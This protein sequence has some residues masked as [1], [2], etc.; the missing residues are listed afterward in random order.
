MHPPLPFLFVGLATASTLTAQAKPPAMAPAAP[1]IAAAIYSTRG[2]DKV[3]LV[4]LPDLQPL[5]VYDAGAGAHE[6]AISADGKWALGSAYGGPGKGHQPADN[7]VFVLDLPAGKRAHMVDLGATKR[8]N[9]IAFLGRTSE[10][11]VT[12]EV[13]AQLLR[14][15]AATGKFTAFALEHRT[16]HMLALSPDAKTCFVSHVLPGGITRFDLGTDTPK[17]HG[18][19]PD[20]AEGIAC[21]G[22]GKHVWVGCNRSSKLVVVD[23]ATLKILHEVERDGFPLRVKG[24]PDGKYVAVSCPKSGEVVIYEAGD[25]SK[26]RTL[27]LRQALG[28]EVAP[29]S[30]AFSMDSKLLL[31]VANGETDRVLAIDVGKLAIVADVPAAGPIADALA[32]GMVQAPPRAASATK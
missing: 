6:L 26:A 18:A 12:T 15:D 28:A 9:D 24:S 7:R 2:D 3:H 32:A 13:P 31:V 29:T 14:L 10:A 25:V 16:N 1:T 23:N 11:V 8:P 4:S 30:L 21:P 17:A 19:L 20:G 5:A 22:D 27:D